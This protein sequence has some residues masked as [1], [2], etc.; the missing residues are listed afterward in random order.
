[1]DTAWGIHPKISEGQGNKLVTQHNSLLMHA[2]L[3]EI[4]EMKTI[5]SVIEGPNDFLNFEKVSTN[6]ATIIPF[7]SLL[8][9]M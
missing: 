6:N 5:S 9:L 2:M 3:L 1:M 7:L 8:M 4:L